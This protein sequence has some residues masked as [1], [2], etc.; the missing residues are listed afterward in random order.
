LD[1]VSGIPL[2]KEIKNNVDDEIF[3]RNFS[4]RHFQPNDTRTKYILWK[5]SNP[6]GET[7]VNIE[8]I[9]T[10]HILPR[11][12]SKKWI[13]YLKNETFKNENEIKALHKENFNRIGNLT[14]IKGEWNLRMSNRLFSEK[15]EDYK[16]SEFQITKNLFN[17][18]KWTFE[19]IDKRS[20][21]L[22]EEACNVW[23]I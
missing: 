6:T 15:K 11:T 7:M 18:E 17:Y 10:E 12:L 4:Q 13:E 20:K 19:E 22:A 5:L 1:N 9:Q 16:K 21:Q 23:K 3:K 14:I 8:Q 2:L